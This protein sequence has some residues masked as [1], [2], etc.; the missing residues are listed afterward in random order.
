[1]ATWS[2]IGSVVR[3]LPCEK[4]NDTMWSVDFFIDGT[5]RT[6]RVFL[7]YE[8]VKPDME[9]VKAVSPLAPAQAL[10]IEA[11]VRK[12]GSLTI[13]SF[14]Y[15]QFSGGGGSLF[16]GS[17]VPLQLLDLS[18]PHAFLLYLQL[19]AQAADWIK[20]SY[21]DQVT[22]RVDGLYVCPH[23]NY[24][25]YLR[26]TDSG[27]V[28]EVGS[29]GSP[30]Q[31]AS[32]LGPGKSDVSQGTYLAE[33]GRL[34]FTTSSPSGQVSYHGQ[35]SGDA[36]ELRLQ[37]HSYINGSQREEVYSFVSLPAR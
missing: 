13:G 8:V 21:T 3:V 36:A 14:S 29:T 16:L 25:S 19:L 18:D 27:N 17:S 1:M 12:F 11:V 35:I 23:G 15:I 4:L 7:E 28:S 22:P 34:R 6:Q 37:I 2:Q 31:V 10:D 33:G 20:M 26:F 32:W 5:D 24:S 9:F 30:A